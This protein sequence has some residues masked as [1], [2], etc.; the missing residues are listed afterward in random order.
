MIDIEAFTPQVVHHGATLRTQP[1]EQHAG[2][3]FRE[4]AIARA[5]PCAPETHEAVQAETEQH[6]RAEHED[7]AAAIE[8]NAFGRNALQGPGQQHHREREIH[9]HDRQQHLFL[10]VCN[11]IDQLLARHVSHLLALQR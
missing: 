7:P 2:E 11:A 1:V 3:A 9:D 6:Q 10:A 5:L 4:Q 8:S